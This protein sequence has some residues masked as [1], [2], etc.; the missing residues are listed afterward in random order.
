MLSMYT[1]LVPNQIMTI[2]RQLRWNLMSRSAVYKRIVCGTTWPTPID[3]QKVACPVL[4]IGA[5]KV[6]VTLNR[7]SI[8]CCT[9]ISNA[10]TKFDRTTL[11]PLMTRKSLKAILSHAKQWRMDHH[12]QVRMTKL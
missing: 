9:Q 1:A 12:L 8:R 5:E 10:C 11:F 7:L 6:C 2:F 4:L 3:Y